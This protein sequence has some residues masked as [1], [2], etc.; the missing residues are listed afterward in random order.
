MSDFKYKCSECGRSFE[1]LP[2][3]M[4]CPFCRLAQTPG[5]PLRGILNVEM[6][7]I[8][9]GAEFNVFDFLPVEKRFFPK[10][11][12]GITPLW[13][14]LRARRTIGLAKLFIKN[15]ANNPTGSLKDRALIW[16]LPLP[17]NINFAKS[18]LRRRVMQVPPWQASGPPPELK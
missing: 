7:Q 1:I 11:P 18:F 14:V 9:I 13:P 2:S 4:L 8:N 15:D 16:L 12:V 5:E 17:E 10:I 6:P 3:V